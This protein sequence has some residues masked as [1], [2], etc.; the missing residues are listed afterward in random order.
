[1]IHLAGR[2]KK[3]PVSSND[4]K[5]AQAITE[6]SIR[7]PGVKAGSALINENEAS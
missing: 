1:M 3:I 7:I 2:N 6:K 4:G 5:S